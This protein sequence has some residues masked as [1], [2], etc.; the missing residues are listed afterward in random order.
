MEVDSEKLYQF[1]H[2]LNTY[3]LE[4]S[5]VPASVLG[6]GEISS[7]VRIEG[8]PGM[9]FKR[10]P[11]FHSV[12]SAKRYASDYHKY[13]DALKK[14]G[15]SLPADKTQ[16]I[17]IEGRPVV[18]YI[19]Q[20]QLPAEWFCHK[21]I[22]AL[23][24]DK[25]EVMITG[26]IQSIDLVWKFNRDNKPELELAIDGQISNWVWDGTN[27]P[28]SLLFVDTSTPLF[29]LN[30]IEQLDPELFLKSAPS[31]LRWII[32]LLFLKEVMNHYYD[33]VKV[34]IDLA[35]NLYKEQRPDLIPVVIDIINKYLEGKHEKITQ[36]MVRNYYR[37]D[38]L[39]WTVFL[40]FRRID[41]WL[42]QHIFKE[43][44]EF[45]LPGKVKR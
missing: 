41:R 9:A 17:Q 6:Y 12:K 25:I 15:L 14:A 7:I 23:S 8:M 16:I 22:H 5:V 21:L 20:E 26:I 30:G 37:E 35:A 29:R 34:Y 4:Q 13:C 10:M 39:T 11:L 36:K 43:R 33:P 19:V 32:R 42:K 3:R 44:Y 1:E 38:K 2:G 24:L 45:I 28:G 27:N 40:T 18:L 31:S